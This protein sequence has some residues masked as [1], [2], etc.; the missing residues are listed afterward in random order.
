MENIRD[1]KMSADSKSRAC[2]SYKFECNCGY[3]ESNEEEQ[4]LGDDHW[5]ISRICPECDTTYKRKFQV[6][7]EF[8]DKT[9][10]IK[11]KN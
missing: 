7:I 10:K 6:I 9:E 3:R 11:K 8:T 5:R 4:Y 2:L 1:V